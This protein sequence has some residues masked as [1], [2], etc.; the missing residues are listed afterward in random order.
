MADPARARK[1]ADRIQ[2]LIAANLQQVVKDPDLGFVTITD[3][4]VTGDLQHASV[5]Y[6]VFGDDAQRERSAEVLEANRGKLRSFVGKQ[7]GI[8]LTPT[9]EIIP[10]AVPENASHIDDLLRSARERDADL[11]RSRSDAR[12][13]GEADPYRSKDGEGEDTPPPSRA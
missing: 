10:D 2:E 6:T 8:R 11:A 5:F 7:L 13:A 4:R 12:P 1:I 9:L 3:V